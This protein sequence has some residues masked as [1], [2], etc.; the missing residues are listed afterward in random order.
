M[1]SLRII[2]YEEKLKRLSEGLSKS[3]VKKDLQTVNRVL[4]NLAKEFSGVFHYYTIT[5][6]DNSLIKQPNSPIEVVRIDFERDE[7]VCSK[8]TLPEVYSLKTNDL[9]LSAEQ[10]LRQFIRLTERESV[11]CFL[12]FELGL[13][14]IFHFS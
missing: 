5:V 9:T 7:K 4:G 6:Q 10:I 3:R 1:L 8:L 14:F 12:T 2:R 13:R 11:F